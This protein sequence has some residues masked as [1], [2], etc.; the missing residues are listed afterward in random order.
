MCSASD[1]HRRTLTLC[2]GS[3]GAPTV[4]YAYAYAMRGPSGEGLSKTL[5]LRIVS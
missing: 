1:P 3:V 2:A 4:A 5:D